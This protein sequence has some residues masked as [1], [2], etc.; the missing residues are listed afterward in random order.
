MENT[1]RR[2]VCG[3]RGP[4][5][6]AIVSPHLRHAATH[7]YKSASKSTPALLRVGGIDTC[8]YAVM[9]GPF[10]CSS[11]SCSLNLLSYKRQNKGKTIGAVK[12][13]KQQAV[14]HPN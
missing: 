11:I 5:Q 1:L 7:G 12:V 8:L 6:T 2:P 4:L 14:L 13:F 10:I 3:S 9:V